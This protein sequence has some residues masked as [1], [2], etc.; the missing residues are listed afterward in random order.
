M[1]FLD[2]LK[3]FVRNDISLNHLYLE[4]IKNGNVTKSQLMTELRERYLASKYTFVPFMATILANIKPDDKNLILVRYTLVNNL[5]DELGAGKIENA[6]IN[7]WHT[8]LRGVGFQDKQFLKAKPSRATLNHA[9]AFINIAKTMPTAF[10]MGA[11]AY[12]YEYFVIFEYSA[13]LEGC[14]N[15][16]PNLTAKDL[17]QLISHIGHDPKHAD[18]AINALRPYVSQKKNKK[19]I[20]GGVKEALSIKRQYFDTRYKVLK[21]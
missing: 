3:G 6:H 11:F 16:F 19:L 8:L 1:E 12:G 18:D 17:F 2:R 20:L 13:F 7:H 14:K 9:N 5:F 4:T 15:L 21:P 10:S